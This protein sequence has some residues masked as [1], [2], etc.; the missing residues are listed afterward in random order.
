MG[1]PGLGLG[2]VERQGAHKAASHILNWGTMR[3]LPRSAFGYHVAAASDF[4]NADILIP[5]PMT[6]RDRRAALHA[7]PGDCA[8]PLLKGLSGWETK[9]IT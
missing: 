6:K 3:L 1:C 9:K 2:R 7:K 8:A 5:L 4:N